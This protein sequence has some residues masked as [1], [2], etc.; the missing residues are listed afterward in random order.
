MIANK[1]EMKI[2]EL[3]Y[4]TN[5]NGKILVLNQN[6]PTLTFN[7]HQENN[8]NIFEYDGKECFDICIIKEIFKNNNL[9]FYYEIPE[10]YSV[11]YVNTIYTYYNN[12]VSTEFYECIDINDNESKERLNLFIEKINKRNKST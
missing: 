9:Q 2:N 10:D 3:Y 4:S 12:S 7:A 6:Y 8:L 5:S 1:K 11:Y